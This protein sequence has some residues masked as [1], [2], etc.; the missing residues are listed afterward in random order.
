[1]TRLALGID[2]GGTRTRCVVVDE[3]GALLG[4]GE[5]PGA[6]PNSSRDIEVAFAAAL[7]GATAHLQPQAVPAIAAAVV[8]VAGAGPAGRPAVEAA[9]RA[10]AVSSEIHFEIL[11]VC[12]D[13]EA[14][15]AAGSAEPD[16][17]VLIAGTGAVAAQL[18][19]FRV[20]R[21]RDGHGYLLGDAGSAFWVGAAAVRA[22]LAEIEGDGPRTAMRTA[23]LDRL[24]HDSTVQ[25]R[26]DAATLDDVQTMLAAVYAH[27]PARLAALATLVDDAAEQGDPEARRI[28]D[29]AVQALVHSADVVRRNTAP[30]APFVVTGGVATGA[31]A[32]ARTLRAALES[33]FAVSPRFVPDGRLGAAALALR[34]LPGV[35]PAAVARLVC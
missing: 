7:A 16:G 30:N 10:A 21:R 35:D 9:V 32:L 31:G 33:R 28:V 22:V 3:H 14:A 5:G 19:G 23:V 29:D 1:V 26:A 11:L 34:Q 17:T 25:Q 6:N 27:P 24:R 18:A 12:S 20:V 2:A 4:S 15:F 8:A 13:C